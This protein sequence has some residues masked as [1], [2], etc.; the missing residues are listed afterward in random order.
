MLQLV[1]AIILIVAAKLTFDIIREQI[2]V[3]KQSK[4]KGGK[5]LI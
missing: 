5:L 4:P 2:K 1:G 3:T